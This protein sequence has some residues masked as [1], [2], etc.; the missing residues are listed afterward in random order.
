MTITPSE[1]RGA[2][3]GQATDA[4]VRRDFA[5]F[6]PTTW[7]DEASRLKFRMTGTERMRRTIRL[8]FVMGDLVRKAH[9]DET[10]ALRLPSVCIPVIGRL[11][12]W[13]R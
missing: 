3:D 8:V 6:R 12:D 11:R 13:W 1:M 5:V 7:T 10:R 9:L 4:T 2:H